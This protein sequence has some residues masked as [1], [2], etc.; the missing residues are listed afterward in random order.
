MN[1][2]NHRN[3]LTRT[4]H[5]IPVARAPQDGRSNSTVHHQPLPAS[6]DNAQGLSFV[7]HALRRWWK[8]VVPAGLLVGGA[9]AAAVYLFFEP[10]YEGVSWLRITNPQY[11]AFESKSEDGTSHKVFAQTQIEMLRSPMVLGPVLGDPQIARMPEIAKQPDPLQWLAKQIAVKQVGESEF[12]Q[13]IY[14]ADDPESATK[15][16]KAVVN[17]YFHLRGEEEVKHIE[18]VINIL[19]QERDSRGKGVTLLRESVRDLAKQ[20]TGKDPFAAAEPAPI[21]QNPLADIQNNLVAAEVEEEVAKARLKALENAPPPRAVAAES[22]LDAKIDERP[23]IRQLQAE[24]AFKQAQ[25]RDLAAYSNRGG[26]DPQSAQLNIDIKECEKAIAQMRTNLRKTAQAELQAL[27]EA[28]REEQLETLKID[29]ENR[30]IAVDMLHERYESR[31]KDLKQTSGDTLQLRFKQGELERAE[32]IYSL[33]AERIVKL[34]TESGAPERVVLMNEAKA[35]TTPVNTPYRNM[36]LAALGGLGLPFGLALLRE[37][38]V[39][40]VG[41]AAHL[42]QD[43]KFQVLGEIAQ[44]P[45]GRLDRHRKPSPQPDFESRI[46]EES[47]D[48]LRTRLMLANELHGLRIIAIASAGKHE[49]KTSV[50]AQLSMSL[51]RATNMPTLLIDGDMRDPD[52]HDMFNVP[53]EPGLTNVLQGKISLEEAIVPTEYPQLDILPGGILRENPHRLLAGD[54]REAFLR[55]IPA[56]YR[57]VIID[58][59][60]V[61]AA[62][63]ALMLAALADATLVC[64]LRDVSR[65]E[66]VRKAYAR[67]FSAGG[68]PVGLVL[69]GVPAKNY[70]R[71]YGNYSYA[72]T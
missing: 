31:V 52:L 57:Y 19:E 45:A 43:A 51:A 18:K 13:V 67:L 27:A 50:A 32:K 26:K 69:N 62:S 16:N 71:Q 38:C 48:C 54:A 36:I 24:L 59:P 34:R 68:K 58:T 53:L 37:K 39:R 29:A 17:E 25:L 9:A 49:G 41:D 56:K 15:V 35:S 3:A 60:P 61:L 44:L 21:V 42:E 46:F 12:Y 55:A 4:A 14:A 30:H 10:T 47:I 33:I 5:S 40:R 63:E 1:M 66:Q 11:I 20:A 23:E 6:P 28:R 22:L 7:L 64:A 8:W 65:V 72:G 70:V 2:A